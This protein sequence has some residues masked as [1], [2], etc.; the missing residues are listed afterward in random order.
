MCPDGRRV[1]PLFLRGSPLIPSVSKD[2][3]STGLLYHFCY[4]FVND[5]M[6]KHT[7]KNAKIFYIFCI[8]VFCY[9]VTFFLSHFLHQKSQQTPAQTTFRYT[10]YHIS[11][12]APNSHTQQHTTSNSHATPHTTFRTS[13]NPTPPLSTQKIK[14]NKKSPTQSVRDN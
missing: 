8:K 5:F 2:F 9:L 4:N 1:S 12:F 6:L 3:S 11:H 10:R 7:H 14:D 13:H